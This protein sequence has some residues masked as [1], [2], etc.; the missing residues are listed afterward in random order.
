MGIGLVVQV[1][2]PVLIIFNYMRSHQTFSQWLHNF[3]F[4]LAMYESSCFSS[5]ST[6]HVVYIFLL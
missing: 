1:L 4:L 6:S 5:S 2:G 3:T